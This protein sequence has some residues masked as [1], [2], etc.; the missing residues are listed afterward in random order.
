MSPLPP[1]PNRKDREGVRDRSG[2]RLVRAIRFVREYGVGEVFRLIRRHGL[3]ESAKFTVRQIR[4][5]IAHQCHRAYDRRHNVDTGGDV[6]LQYLSVTGENAAL[7]HQYVSTPTRTFRHILANL[8]LRDF[9]DFAFIDIGCGKGRTLLLAA[10]YPFRSVRG[11]EFARELADI[12]RRNLETWR[13]P[14][15]RCASVEVE[16]ADGAKATF[17]PT[18]LVIYFY[19]PFEIEIFEKVFT[20]IAADLRA[21]PRPVFLVYACMDEK[22]L[23]PVARVVSASS[24]FREIPAVPIRFIFEL[25]LPT[26]YIAYAAGI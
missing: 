7:G 20:N 3:R 14:P 5:I 22:V 19:D 1:S 12:A 21:N 11:I 9:S 25:A 17:P 15:R 8:P 10:E 24:L 6:Q 23:P 4:Y 13:G 16:C 18:P 2:S 26:H